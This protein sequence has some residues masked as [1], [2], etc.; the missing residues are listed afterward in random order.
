MSVLLRPATGLSVRRRLAL[1]GAG[2]VAACGLMIGA[3]APATAATEAPWGS[4]G[5]SIAAGVGA[6]SYLN[7][8]CYLSTKSYPKL[9]DADADK[10]L[11]SFVP[12]NGA[13]T[14]DVISKQIPALATG[15]SVVTVSVG[16]NDVGF[17]DVMTNCFVLVNSKCQSKIDA[18][19]TAM[20]S[21]AFAANVKAVIDGVRARTGAQVIV[22]GYPLLFWENS[23]GVNPKYKW[24]DEGEVHR[25]KHS[26]NKA[27]E[28]W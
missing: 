4:V 6:G 11:V 24:G 20:N 21:A 3:A 1:A 28:R 18:G 12:C 25:A 9:L 7:T 14:A 17:S 23:K 19:V 16:A 26:L 8:T 10:Q 22:T 13:T 27:C 15:L 5:D 2:L